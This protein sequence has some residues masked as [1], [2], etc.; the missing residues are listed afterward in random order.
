MTQL[1]PSE[2]KVAHFPLADKIEVPAVADDNG[3]T[4][5]PALTTVPA[6]M[7]LIINCLPEND[8]AAGRV[9]VIV[10]ALFTTSDSSVAETVYVVVDTVTGADPYDQAGAADAPPDIRN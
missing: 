1:T 3:T 9:M 8:A 10:L 7:L 4:F 6:P 5:V 2:I